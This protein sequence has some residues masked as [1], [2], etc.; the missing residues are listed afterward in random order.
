MS[1]RARKPNTTTELPFP[2]DFCLR[3]QRDTLNVRVTEGA[4]AQVESPS[5]VAVIE[6]VPRETSVTVAP[7]TVQTPVLFDINVTASPELAVALKANDGVAKRCR[8]GNTPNVIVCALPV[9]VNV[10]VT[11]G[12][13]AQVELPSW[14]AVIEHVPSVSSVTVTPDTV[15]TAV[16]LE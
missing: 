2:I 4:G 11:A 14:V 6:H 15:H 7:D 8:S 9:T 16:L 10:C 12:A 1:A 5:W 13:A 3:D